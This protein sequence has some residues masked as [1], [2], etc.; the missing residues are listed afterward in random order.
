MAEMREASV[1]PNQVTCSILLKCLHAHSDEKNFTRTR[2]LINTFDES[3]GEV[4]LSSVTEAC[5]RIGKPVCSPR[6]CI[7]CTAPRG[8]Q[9]Q[10]LIPLGAALRPTAIRRTSMAC[11]GVGRDAESPDPAD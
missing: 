5:I 2:D 10:A 11:G 7:G 1:K 9:S 3:M 8:S 6:R 4:L